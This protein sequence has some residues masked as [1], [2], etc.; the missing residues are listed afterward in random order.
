MN[1]NTTFSFLWNP[2]F[3]IIATWIWW[4]VGAGLVLWAITAASGIGFTEFRTIY[5]QQ[6]H[7]LIYVE[8]VGV[9]LFPLALT[10]LCRDDW[11]LYGVRG[12]RLGTSL[13]WSA[14]VMIANSAYLFL[15]TGHW[16]NWRILT[17]HV[18]FPANLWYAILGVFAYGPLEMFF[19]T[20]LIA[21]TEKAIPGGLSCVSWGLLVTVV[22]VGLAHI[23]A[24]SSMSSA[25]YVTVVFLLLGLVFKFTGNALGPMI[26]WTVINGQVWF[27]AQFLWTW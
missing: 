9:G 2:V 7:L 11:A 8:V 23:A 27:L 22:L 25:L 16:M 20:W 18:G 17:V 19:V 4:A 21:N 1:Q 6:P 13:V 5:R 10:I 14:V 3:R 24:T 26:A 12:D 15:T